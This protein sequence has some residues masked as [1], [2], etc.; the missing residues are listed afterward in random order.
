[1]KQAIMRETAKTELT[2]LMDGDVRDYL[3]A[4]PDFLSSNTDLLGVLTPPRQ[5]LDDDVR[6][7]QR[8]MLAHLQKGIARL[9]DDR[10][11]GVQ[12]LQE[13]MHRQSR[14]NVATLSLLEAPSFKAMLQTIE[15]DFPLLLD[16]E[17]VELMIEEGGS[18]LPGLRLIPEGFVQEWLP[19]RDMS[20]E[21]E[22]HGV[23][24][25]YGRKASRVRSQALVRLS[26]SSEVPPGLLALG[27]RDS[28][29]Y[30]T[31]LA[32]EQV[33]HMAALIELCARKW[34]DLPV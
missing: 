21:G 23:Y 7:F 20:L 10:D 34:L 12:L 2:S 22:I 13:H 28:S 26:I 32:T 18:P 15:D 4:H 19:N 11:H 1:L 30:A 9:K 31:G 6:D 3:L 8:F 25:L 29:Y 14:M 5:R 33:S 27:H 24:E 16:H 17:A